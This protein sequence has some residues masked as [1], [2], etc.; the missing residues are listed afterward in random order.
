MANILTAALMLFSVHHTAFADDTTSIPENVLTAADEAHVD[1][2]DLVAALDSQ[3]LTDPYAYLRGTGELPQTIPKGYSARV[4]VTYYNLTG[5][6]YSGIPLY[7]GSTACSWDYAIGTKFQFPD[8]EIVTCIDRGL[9]GSGK[10]MGWLDVWQNPGLAHKYEP[11][12]I[13]TVLN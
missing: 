13:V 6:T 12:T 11:S 1:P 10:P 8:G 5:R 9:L 4:R 2:V 3:G 7:P